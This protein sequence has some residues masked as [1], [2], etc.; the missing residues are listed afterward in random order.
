MDDT[1]QKATK[2]L[3]DMMHFV[4]NEAVKDAPYDVT[5]NARITKVYYETDVNTIIGYDVKVDDKE[6][7]ITKESGKG[8][9]ARENDVVK[10][11]FPCNNSNNIYLSYPHDPEDFIKYF[12][13]NEGSEYIMYYNT[14]R[15]EHVLNYDMSVTFPATS[16]QF[17][18]A[19]K[20]IQLVLPT[21][22]THYSFEVLCDTGVWGTVTD[23]LVNQSS[24]INVKLYNENPTTT[25]PVTKTIN[26]YIKAMG[27]RHQL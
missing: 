16:K 13:T 8:I 12:I 6:Y 7:H 19:T 25:D 23:S 9:I 14:G 17:S 24:T 18:S 15:Y 21:S 11:H 2:E 3:A 22:L 20:N 10:A 1:N 5:R 4:A 27:V 26:F